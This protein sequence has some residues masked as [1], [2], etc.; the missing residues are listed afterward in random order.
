[1]KT[2]AGARRQHIINEQGP[3]FYKETIGALD[4]DI[5]SLTEDLAGDITSFPTTVQVQGDAGEPNAPVYI[6][7][8]ACPAVNA[9][10]NLQLSQEQISLSYLKVNP[11]PIAEG[12]EHQYLSVM[13]R[14]EVGEHD[15]PY[16]VG[17]FGENPKTFHNPDQLARYIMELLFIV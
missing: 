17:P 3:A 10:L 4:R 14:F 12:Q 16:L 15:G 13:F 5:K 9:N 6:T 1:L 11:G 2:Q 7:R 8:Q